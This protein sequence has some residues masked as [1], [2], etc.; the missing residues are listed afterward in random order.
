MRITTLGY[1]SVDS[2]QLLV[3][4]PCYVWDD[5]FKGDVPTGKPYDTACR[6]TLDSKGYGEVEGGVVFGTL[7]GDG[8]YR[9]KAETDR[10]GRVVRVIID[11]DF[12]DFEDDEDDEDF[13]DDEDLA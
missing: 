7:H 4:D 10:V 13:D 11:L 5:P 2:G 1:A 3:I 6:L 9:I 12:E 8:R